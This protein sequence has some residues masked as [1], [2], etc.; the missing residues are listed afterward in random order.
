MGWVANQLEDLGPV[1]LWLLDDVSGSALADQ[2]GVNPGSYT[3]VVTKQ[4]TPLTPDAAGQSALFGPDGYLSVPHSSDFQIAN[5]WSFIGWYGPR[6]RATAAAF[7]H[8]G[9][10]DTSGQQ[11]LAI[12]SDET[13]GAI[14]AGWFNGAWAS[15]QS[16]LYQPVGQ[17]FFFAVRYN[18]AQHRLYFQVG[19]QSSN[20][21][22]PQPT[23]QAT[24]SSPLILGAE[25]NT[26]V[27]R[28]YS[29]TLD[30]LD[31]LIPEQ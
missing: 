9:K 15:I 16:G 29:S 19:D 31:K 13:T 6:S 5:D 23:F 22:C 12:R 20:V 18:A 21:A 27:Y 1:G 10:F 24:V 14:S 4:Q 3:G 8:K 2:M 30:N 11:G 7:F 17:A 26:S 25:Y 28:H